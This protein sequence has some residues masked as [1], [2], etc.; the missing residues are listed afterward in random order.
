MLLIFLKNFVGRVRFNHKFVE[1]ID[2]CQET[3]R[4]FMDN[5]HL[6]RS[7]VGDM[8]QDEFGKKQYGTREERD[9]VK[10]ISGIA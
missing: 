6:D 5:I 8:L 10:N 9:V 4:S 7:M 3:V 2:R 1:W